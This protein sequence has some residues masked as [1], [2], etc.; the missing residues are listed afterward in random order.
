[1]KKTALVLGG[2][3]PTFTLMTGALLAFDQ[4]GAK[5]DVVSMAGGGAVAGLPYLAPKGMTRQEALQNSVNIGVSDPIYNIFP[6]NYKVFQKPG[7]AA[8]LYRLAWSMM[9]GYAQIMNQL[10][11]SPSEKFLS[12]WIQFWVDGL[13]PSD[14]SLFSKGM[15]AH[16]PFIRDLVDFD[17]LPTLETDFYLNS[18]CLTDQKMAIFGKDVANLAHFQASL[19]YPFFYAP[20]DIGGKLYI[21]GA[22]RDAFNFKGLLEH[23]KDID[24]IVVFDAIAIDGL[25]HPARNLWDS[26][27]QQIMTP[28]IALAHADLKLFDLVHNQGPDKRK[29]LIVDFEIPPNLLPNALDWSS[30]NLNALFQVGYDTGNAFIDKYGPKFDKA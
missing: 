5:F 28:L 9:P 30:S 22:S 3:A 4:R 14:L 17:A 6:I 18:Y 27:G 21:E 19:S 2:G 20:F 12:D 7:L 13:A 11:M 29:L 15:C 24:T 16:A 8:S 23:E 10:N 25:L 26:F 1:M